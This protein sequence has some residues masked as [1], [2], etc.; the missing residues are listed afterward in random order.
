MTANRFDISKIL[1]LKRAHDACS[2]AAIK[3]LDR[4]PAAVAAVATKG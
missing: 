1:S 3:P 2:T 4:Q